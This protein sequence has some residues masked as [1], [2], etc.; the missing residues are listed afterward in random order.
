[1]IASL[2]EKGAQPRQRQEGHDF[3]V[4]KAAVA[5]RFAEMQKGQLFR[6][7]VSG[8]DLWAAYLASFP[9]GTNLIYRER[10][11]YDCSCCRHFVRSVGAVVAVE[12]GQ[13]VSLWDIEIADPAY[14]TVAAALSSLARSKPLAG[15]FVHYE[16]TAG[17]D[18]NVELLGPEGPEPTRTWNHFFVN[19]DRRHI[20]PKAWIATWLGEQ[21]SGQKSL[22]AT[23]L[24]RRPIA[25]KRSCA[26]SP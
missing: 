21:R 9:P 8:D 22:S 10:T 12:D 2:S 23:R 4:F 11:E 18:R 15:P 25:R 5:R 24:A 20:Q 1:M 13:L 19:I 26:S 17:T 16:A 6:A 7:D 14:A 3:Q